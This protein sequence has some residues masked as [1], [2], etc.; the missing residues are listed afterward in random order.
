MCVRTT[1]KETAASILAAAA[2]G[3]HIRHGARAAREDI[4][5]GIHDAGDDL[6]D[7]VTA[8]KAAWSQ[9][10]EAVRETLADAREQVLS[11]VRAKPLNALL[12][13]GAVGFVLARL[14]RRSR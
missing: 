5:D 9:A 7:A 12:M 6:D 14:L 8:G 2:S 13:A 3:A 4:E 1:G 11:H 10:S